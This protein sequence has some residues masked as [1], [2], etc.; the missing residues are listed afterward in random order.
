MRARVHLLD[1]LRNAAV[2]GILNLTRPRAA[3]RRTVQ[4]VPDASGMLYAA[5]F[6]SLAPLPLPLDFAPLSAHGRNE[7]CRGGEGARARARARETPVRCKEHPQLFQPFRQRW[8]NSVPVLEHPLKLSLLHHAQ[9][10]SSLRGGARRQA[11]PR[12]LADPINSH[13]VA[14]RWLFPAPKVCRPWRRHQARPPPGRGQ[15]FVQWES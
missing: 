4:L 5:R 8:T 6:E 12:P 11:L 10:A 15:Q 13:V 7:Q 3:T 9:G 2:R 1:S 14:A